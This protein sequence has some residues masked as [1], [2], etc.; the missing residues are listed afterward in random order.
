MVHG[1]CVSFRTVV[2]ST[3]LGSPAPPLMGYSGSGGRARYNPCDQRLFTQ[4]ERVS[5]KGHPQICHF[6]CPVL[7]SMSCQLLKVTSHNF[8]GDRMENM[9]KGVHVES[10]DFH[11]ID[12]EWL[13][14]AGYT[15]CAPVIQGCC[16][17]SVHLVYTRCTP[18]LHQSHRAAVPNK[19]SCTFLCLLP[20][21]CRPRFPPQQSHSLLAVV[22]LTRKK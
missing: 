3:H 22:C 15:R 5:F 11:P 7:S 19:H 13:L 2:R 8:T 9:A 12:L 6:L 17:P 16:S 14:D 10:T 20:F 21:L 18:G 4:Y 1:R